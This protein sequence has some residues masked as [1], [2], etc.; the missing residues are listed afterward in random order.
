MMFF[1]TNLIALFKKIL[2]LQQY[3]DYGEDKTIKKLA[4]LGS[5]SYLDIGAGHPIIGSNTYYFYKLGCKGVTIEPI[6]FH[7]KLHRFIRRKDIQVNALVSNSNEKRDFYEYNPTQYS[8][9]SFEQY[10]KLTLMGMRPRKI[11]KVESVSVNK[12]ISLVCDIPFFISIDC[13]GFDLE[14]L[15]QIHPENYKNAFAVII[16][17]PHLQN[18]KNKIYSILKLNGYRL[19][20]TTKNNF[21]F[22]KV[23]L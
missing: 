22:Q 5:I 7:S 12:M 10:K 8:T 15:K 19:H 9:T 18:D 23:N 14:I 1:K 20:S 3:S 11:Y 21:I 4:P 2:P 17:I 13:E 6:N 16:E